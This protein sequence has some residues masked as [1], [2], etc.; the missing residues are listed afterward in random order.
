MSGTGEF[1]LP[2]LL[3]AHA[4]RLTGISVI[5]SLLKYKKRLKVAGAWRIPPS[6]NHTWKPAVW[7]VSARGTVFI[8]GGW[9]VRIYR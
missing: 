1:A 4:A 6:Q 8:P 3:D 5:T 2:P 7:S 9:T